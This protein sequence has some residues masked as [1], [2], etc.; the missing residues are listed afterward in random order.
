M[1]WLEGRHESGGENDSQH[2]L[3]GRKKIKFIKERERELE[4]G[5]AL[6]T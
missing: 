1:A 6:T 5:G 4:R 3:L 2:Q